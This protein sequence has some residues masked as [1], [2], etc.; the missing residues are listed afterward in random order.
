MSAR[1]TVTISRELYAELRQFQVEACADLEEAADELVR[2]RAASEP[3]ADTVRMLLELAQ[4]DGRCVYCGG[5]SCAA[6]CPT[7]GA[8]ETLGTYARPKG[9]C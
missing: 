7:L 8:A 5:E 4:R 1:R 9:D 6:P 2:A 3:L